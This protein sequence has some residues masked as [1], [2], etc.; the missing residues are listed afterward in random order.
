MPTPLEPRYMQVQSQRRPADLEGADGS[1]LVFIIKAS[2]FYSFPGIDQ[3]ARLSI[4]NLS[5]FA[6]RPVVRNAC[7]EEKKETA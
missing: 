5:L 2:A 7:G 1:S 6:S 4:R 3:K